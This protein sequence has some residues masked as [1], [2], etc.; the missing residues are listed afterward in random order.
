MYT[1]DD[2]DVNLSHPKLSSPWVL[3]LNNIV[4]TLRLN[5]DPEGNVDAI[6]RHFLNATLTS[7]SSQSIDSLSDEEFQQRLM[8]RLENAQLQESMEQHHL[9]IPGSKNEP[10]THFAGDI[11]IRLVVDFPDSMA[12]LGGTMI[13]DRGDLNMLFRTGMHNLERELRSMPVEVNK[14]P[15]PENPA[16][17]AWFLESSSEYFGSFPLMLGEFLAAHLPEADLDSGLL[18]G[19][20]TRHYAIVVP[21]GTGEGFAGSLQ[22][23]AQWVASTFSNFP[24]QISPCLFQARPDEFVPVSQLQPSDEPGAFKL[25]IFPNEYLMERLNHE[26]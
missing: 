21:I 7:T 8:A 13:T 3:S 10:F 16:D 12:A 18:I 24:A 25:A 5:D 19:I 9:S 11:N 26:E 22:S 6:V 20:P 2:S 23:A 14:V 15:S 4:R 1:L 17:F